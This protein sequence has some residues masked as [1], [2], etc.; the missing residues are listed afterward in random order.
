[1]LFSDEPYLKMKHFVTAFFG[2]HLQGQE[3]YQKYFSEDVVN[4]LENIAW[5]VYNGE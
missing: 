1:M 3:K 2:Y 4:R 5:G